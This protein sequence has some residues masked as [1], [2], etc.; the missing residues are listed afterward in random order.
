MRLQLPILHIFLLAVVIAD[1]NATRGEDW[2]QFLGPAR[3]GVSQEKI[4][5][6]WTKSGPKQ[7]WKKKVGAGFA[8]P[9]VSGDTLIVFHREGNSEILL[10]LDAESGKQK[11]RANLPRLIAMIL[12]SMKDRAPRR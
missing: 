11:W 1:L 2:P 3:N 5:D 8:G 7:V 9:A 10:A 12:A 4:A 6:S